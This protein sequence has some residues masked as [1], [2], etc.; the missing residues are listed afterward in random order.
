MQLVEVTNVTP[1]L[2]NE[3][4]LIGDVFEVQPVDGVKSALLLVRKI[5]GEMNLPYKKG[6]R[7]IDKSM[8]N[9]IDETEL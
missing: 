5:K 9:E 2:Q 8:V 4:V 1:S 3:G 6:T 7:W